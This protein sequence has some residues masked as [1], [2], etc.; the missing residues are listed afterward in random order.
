MNTE[1]ILKRLRVYL[2]AFSIFVF[3]G[4][5]F[6]LSFLHHFGEE[7]QIMPFILIPAGIVLAALMLIKPSAKMARIVGIGMWIVFVGGIIGMIVHVS[8][9]LERVLEG[10]G[11]ASFGQII[12]SA[13]GGR[14][15]LLAPGV[16][17]IAAAIA[18]FAIYK[19]PAQEK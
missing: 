12:A 17:S 16:L 3:A 13:V 19:Y 4:A 5:I 10:G 15:P 6:E 18:L 7:L 8:G 11:S 9:N 1:T 2:L 14:N